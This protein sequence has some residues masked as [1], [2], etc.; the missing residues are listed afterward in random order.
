MATTLAEQEQKCQ[1]QVKRVRETTLKEAEQHY[2]SCLHEL[3]N[4]SKN[5]PH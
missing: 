4:Y 1:Q 5:K 3:V 2:L